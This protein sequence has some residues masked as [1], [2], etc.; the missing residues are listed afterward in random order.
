MRTLSKCLHL[1]DAGTT[2]IVRT[3]DSIDTSESDGRIYFGVVEQDVM[4]W[5]SRVVS[6]LS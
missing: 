4:D 5:N 3:N 1:I 2:V 6:F